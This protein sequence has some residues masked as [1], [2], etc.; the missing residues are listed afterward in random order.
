MENK[1]DCKYCYYFPCLKVQ[2]SFGN[3]EGCDNFVSIVEKELKEIDKK[4]EE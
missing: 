4:R 2:C 1:K 3:Q